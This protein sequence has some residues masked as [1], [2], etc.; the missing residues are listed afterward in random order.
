MSDKIMNEKMWWEKTVEYRFLEMLFTEMLIQRELKPG[1]CIAPL[2][3]NHEKQS[4]D[5]ILKLSDKWVLIE[6]KRDETCL[7]SEI[8]KYGSVDK[9][10]SAKDKLQNDGGHHFLIYGDSKSSTVLNLKSQLYWG[11][12]ALAQTQNNNSDSSENFLITSIFDN[13]KN[14][15]EFASYLDRLKNERGGTGDGTG[16]S[17]VAMS[18]KDGNLITIPIVKNELDLSSENNLSNN[19]ANEMQKSTDNPEKNCSKND[20]PKNTPKP[21]K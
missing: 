17:A 2:D 18:I 9:Y 6:F 14:Y 20:I 1:S 10:N 7:S 8:P 3:G 11:D 4:G 19:N 12:K 15:E 13:G 16:G 5:V 21:W